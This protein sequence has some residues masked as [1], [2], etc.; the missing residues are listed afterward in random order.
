[1]S[2]YYC[3]YRFYDLPAVTHRTQ[4]VEAES[5]GDVM[6]GFWINGLNKLT[7]GSDCVFWIPPSAI[8]VVE[9]TND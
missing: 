3:W 7:K 8:L 6:G 5:L 2:K 9:K 1:M 4:L